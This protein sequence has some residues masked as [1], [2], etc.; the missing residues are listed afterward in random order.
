MTVYTALES[1]AYLT[2]K[3]NM[4]PVSNYT[5]HWSMG[6]SDSLQNINVMDAV[7]GNQ[8]KSTYFV[9]NVT[10]KELGNYTVR[11]INSAIASEYREV[12]FYVMLKLE[13]KKSKDFML[14]FF[15]MMLLFCILLRNHC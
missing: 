13:G 8:V 2:V 9:S 3:F 4:N 12:A 5:V 1:A 11:V 14:Q 7:I 10:K 6:S 15:Y